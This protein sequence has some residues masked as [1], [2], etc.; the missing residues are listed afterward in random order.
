MDSLTS[1]VAQPRRPARGDLLRLNVFADTTETETQRVA[2]TSRLAQLAPH[3]ALQAPPLPAPAPP[4]RQLLEDRTRRILLGHDPARSGALVLALL[5]GARV[6]D[7]RRHGDRLLRVNAAHFFF[8][9]EFRINQSPP[10]QISLSSPLRDGIRVRV[11]LLRVVNLL[12]FRIFIMRR[13]R[14]C[15][16]RI[17]EDDSTFKNTE[18]NMHLLLFSGPINRIYTLPILKFYF[19]NI[20]NDSFL[21][22]MNS[23]LHKCGRVLFF[24]KRAYY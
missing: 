13:K 5:E 16:W 12:R 2:T 11:N 14:E 1:D 4:R 15:F 7:R 6:I 3:L 8:L 18:E 19:S 9:T 21:V 22:Q 10:R 20:V 23:R 24:F 17:T